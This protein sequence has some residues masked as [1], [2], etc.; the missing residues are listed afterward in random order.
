MKKTT[1]LLSLGLV[2]AMLLSGCG[3]TGNNGNNN[4]NNTTNNN[5]NS[6]NS[7][8]S[9]GTP[10]DADFSQTNED[11]FSNRDSKTDYDKNSILIQLNGDS[12]SC[13]SSAVQ[14]SGSTVTITDEGTYILSG[15]LNNGMIIVNAEESDKP[16]LVLD[17]VTINSETSAPIYILEAD[18]V[19]ITLA[20]GSTNEL[21]NGGTFTAIDENNINS[22]IYS[23]Q[24]LTFNGSGNLTITSPAGHGVSCKDDLVFTSGTYTITSSSHG[25]DANDS[26]RVKDASFTIATGKDGI[27]VENSDDA[28]LGFVYIASGTFDIEAEGDGIS[29]GYYMQIEDGTFDLLCG[30][31]YENG[32]EHSSGNWGNMG[33]GMPG[34]GMGGGRPGRSADSTNNTNGANATTTADT[35]DS[36]TSMKG[37]KSTSSILI[38]GG[39]F[40]IDSADDAIHANASAYINNGSF[41]IASGD[42]AIHA[43]AELTIT[44][45]TANITKC[46]EGLEALEIYITGGDYTINATDD[47]LNASGGADA[48]GMTGGRD[49]MFGGGM[50]GGATSANGNIEISGG[51]LTI[52]ASGDGLD[53]NGNLT[54]SG[55]YTYVTNPTSGDT[56]VLDSQN[57]PVITGGTYIGIG[58]TTM[59]AETFSSSS[60][61]GVIACSVGQQSAGS[62]VSITDANGNT[63]LSLEAEYSVALIIISTPDIVKGDTYDLVVGQASGSI[64]AQ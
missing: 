17:N 20:D 29:A 26:L 56:S 16:Q 57:Q 32:A 46:Y 42:D 30:G 13:D 60:T 44:G 35:D 52:Y 21:S 59:M 47:G 51:K 6:E 9:N 1:K 37:L 48:S 19:F 10:V 38:N 33:G 25:L 58:I 14:I 54:I 61:Q 28:S 34:G 8:T 50:G 62:E 43:E 64:D 49:G 63:I 18:K 55:G 53:S 4:S 22:A 11:M 2:A 39:T 36:S 5:S 31:G 45:G 7:S 40:T 41:E 24:D 27:H 12:A 3:D 15:T 23:K